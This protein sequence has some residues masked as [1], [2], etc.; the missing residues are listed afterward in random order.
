MTVTSKTASLVEERGQQSGRYA[1]FISVNQYL[2]RINPETRKY[3][4]EKKL[5]WLLHDKKG[6]DIE[7]RSYGSRVPAHHP[8]L[9]LLYGVG[10]ALAT[11][12]L[13]Y[14]S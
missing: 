14:K 1:T 11:I 9:F 7:I 4:K 12:T 3:K 2:L 5:L 8:R 6:W 13:F 10:A